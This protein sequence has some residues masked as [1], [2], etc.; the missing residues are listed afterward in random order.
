MNFSCNNCMCE[1]ICSW[2]K[3][4]YC[5]DVLCPYVLEGKPQLWT[6]YDANQDWWNSLTEK[7]RN[8]IKRKNTL[9]PIMENFFL[10]DNCKNKY[11]ENNMCKGRQKNKIG[12]NKIDWF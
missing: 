8:K 5:D 3:N 10:C 11:I 12:Q 4:T 9:K 1:W 2:C 7:K 6:P